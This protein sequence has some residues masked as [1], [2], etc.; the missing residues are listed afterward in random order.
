MVVFCVVT[1]CAVVLW[2]DTNVSKEHA[3]STLRV[4]VHRVTNQLGYVARFQ[5]DSRQSQRIESPAWA[6][7]NG[8]HKNC[9]SQDHNMFSVKVEK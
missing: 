6:S 9:H 7:R 3:A 8:R 5:S 1:P 2:V 4:E